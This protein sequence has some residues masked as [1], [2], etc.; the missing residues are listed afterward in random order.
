MPIVYLTSKCA[1]LS[2]VSMTLKILV[3]LAKFSKEPPKKPT[4]D[5]LPS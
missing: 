2:V 5:V 3:T 4:I 1:E